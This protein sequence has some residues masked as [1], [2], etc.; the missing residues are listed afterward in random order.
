LGIIGGIGADLRLGGW[1]KP[2]DGAI[3]DII[4]Y[5]MVLVRG[6]VIVVNGPIR[7]TVGRRSDGSWCLGGCVLW[8]GDYRDRAL[9]E[10]H[11]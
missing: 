1:S 4:H 2:R 8:T 9:V 3:A 6:T 7:W 10:M 5:W 11:E